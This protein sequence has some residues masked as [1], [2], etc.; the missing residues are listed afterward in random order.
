LAKWQIPAGTII[1]AGGYL[2][3]WCDED[4]ADGPLHANFKLSSTSGESITLSNPNLNIIDQVFFGP[5]S[6]DLGYARVPNGTGNF[7]VQAATFNANN[8]TANSTTYTDESNIDM[9]VFPNPSYGEL[10]VKISQLIDN[11]RIYLFNHLGQLI[12]EFEA[13]NENYL[14]LENMTSGFYFLKYGKKTVKVYII[15]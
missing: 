4:G 12:H 8:E 15:N 3:I 2:I 13:Q 9:S 7:I 14:N 11:E 10:F 1:S 6:A 5:Q